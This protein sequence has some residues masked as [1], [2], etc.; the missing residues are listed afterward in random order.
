[1][2]VQIQDISHARL[3]GAVRTLVTARVVN[4]LGGFT[5]TF[6]PVLLVTAYDASLVAA[7]VVAA[8][9]GLATIP[10]RLLGG[11]LADRL[12]HRTTIVL[13]LTGCAVAQLCLAGAPGLGWALVAAVLLG[14]FFEIYEPPSQALLAD[15]T[16]R[17]QRAG[18]YSALGAA[19]AASGVVAGVLAALLLGFGCAGSSSS[20]PSRASRVRRWCGSPFP[21]AR[22]DRCHDRVR[23]RARGATAGS[24]GCSPPAR[25]PRPF[26][27]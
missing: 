16:P 15:L 10:S 6:L 9:F 22:R 27:W 4:R 1:M 2:T 26:T 14:L 23:A 20:T 19:M 5:L 21:A 18:A 24:W 7:G 3:P 25:R 17:R 13:G 11:R 12:G 8:A